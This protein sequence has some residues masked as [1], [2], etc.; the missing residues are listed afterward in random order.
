MELRQ[1]IRIILS[2]WWIILP[3]T[4]LSFV[5]AMFFSYSQT[6]IYEATS[7][8]I[9]QL[10]SSVA[11]PSNV[12]Y[13]LDTLTG[14]ERIFV[15]FCNVMTSE[16]VRNEAFKIMNIDPAQVPDLA[17]YSTTCN[18]LP[19]SNVIVLYTTGPSQTLIARMNEAIGLA[20]MEVANQVYGTFK[21]VVLDPTKVSPGQIS[22]VHSR[23]G[24]LGLALGLVASVTMAIM[25][26]YLRSP[27][28]KIEAQAVRDGLLNVYNDRFFKRRLDEEIRRARARQRP[29]SIA[30]SKLMPTEDFALLPEDVQESM[31]RLAAQFL[32]SQLGESDLLAYNRKIDTFQFLLPES[33]NSEARETMVKIH[34]EIAIRSFRFNEYIANFE[35]DTGI[36]ESSGENLTIERITDKVMQAIAR[37]QQMAK[38]NIVY[39]RDAPNPFVMEGEE[40]EPEFTEVPVPRREYFNTPENPQKTQENFILDNEA[41]AEADMLM[42]PDAFE[43]VFG[44]P[45]E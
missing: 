31:K 16:A 36:V 2:G 28:E 25:M 9:T 22:P 38:S 45:K 30:Y 42:D 7:S 14:R 34:Q 39:L 41:G 43:K 18:V 8:Y 29:L 32:E 44:K 1:Y 35:L 33:S 11:S 21:L 26:D 5:T 23:N 10:D 13:G 17:S 37:T 27:L 3:I 19:S 4:M 15:T 12:I 40:S 20:G 24:I 6:P